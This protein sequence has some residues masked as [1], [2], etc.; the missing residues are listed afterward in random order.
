MRLRKGQ[1]W[2]LDFISGL[3]LMSLL[4][5]LFILEWNYLSL[6]WNTSATYREMFSGALYASEALFATQGDPPGWERIDV[7]TESNVNSL[8][9]VNSRNELDNQKLAKLQAL[10]SSGGNYT[11]AR[12]KLGLARYQMH[13]K[14]TDLEGNVT[15]YEFGR[16]SG[17]NNSAVFER[18]VI[19]N[20]TIVSKARVEVWR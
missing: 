19:L 5:L 14:I 15:Y 9:L 17:L 13:L 10:N 1:I 18:F 6:R 20:G 7:I 2:S 4:I 12:T 3:T 11:L 16:T 8:G